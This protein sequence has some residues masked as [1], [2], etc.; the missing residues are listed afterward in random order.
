MTIAV[1]AFIFSGTQHLLLIFKQTTRKAFL[2]LTKAKLFFKWFS[3]SDPLQKNPLG[4]LDF[5]SLY[6]LF[7]ISN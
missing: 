5:C 4:S 2:H 3:P 6:D 1:R 7:S